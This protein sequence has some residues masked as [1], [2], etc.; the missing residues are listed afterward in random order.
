[1][2]LDLLKSP[3]QNRFENC[4]IKLSNIALQT[5]RNLSQPLVG[6]DIAISWTIKLDRGRGGYNIDKVDVSL[7]LDNADNFVYILDKIPKSEQRENARLETGAEIVKV[8]IPI[9]DEILVTTQ[10]DVNGVK[11]EFNKM[12]FGKGE[13]STIVEGAIKLKFFPDALGRSIYPTMICN[14]IL[15]QRW[16]SQNL[17][18]ICGRQNVKALTPFEEKAQPEKAHLVYGKIVVRKSVMEQHQGKYHDSLYLLEI[19][20]TTPN[21]MAINCQASLDLHNNPRIIDFVALWNK[22]LSDKISIGHRELLRL[23]TVSSFYEENRPVETELLFD[24][25]SY[26]EDVLDS[27]SIPYTESLNQELR[28][29]LQAEKAYYPTATEV[30]TRTIK[31]II[32]NAVEE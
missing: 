30:F 15:K 19:S 3:L 5:G 6:E 23:F 4:Q 11:W 12:K 24:K 14:A 25:K 20:N 26:I 1:M 13:T 29:F 21:T 28:V 7:K 32:D 22:G 10:P 27:V 9:I 18:L 2:F 17:Q 31:H 16:K 8:T